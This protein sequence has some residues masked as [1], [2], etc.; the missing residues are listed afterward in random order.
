MG[1]IISQIQNIAYIPQSVQSSLDA[2][3]DF[4][5]GLEL[6]GMDANIIIG[7]LF[8]IILFFFVMRGFV[9]L[10]QKYRENEQ[11]LSKLFFIG[12]TNTKK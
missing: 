5:R 2:M 3:K 8:Y 12:T 1:D 7:Y 11:I 6:F 4:T 9:F 10:Y